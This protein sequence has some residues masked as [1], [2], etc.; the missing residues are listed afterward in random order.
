MQKGECEMAAVYH[1][2]SLVEYAHNE[3][4]S[5]IQHGVYM[6]GSKLSALEIAA[7]LGISRTPVVMAINQ[8]VSEGFA[9]RT[10]SRCT[11]VTQL[12]IPQVREI[13]QVR[14]MIELYTADLIVKNLPFQQAIFSQLEQTSQSM[15]E[16]DNHDYMRSCE[17]ETQFHTTFISLCSNSRI[18]KQ[19]ETNW[20]VG[21]VFLLFST[22]QMP[23]Y[24]MNESRIQHQE[25]LELAR[26]GNAAGIRSVAQ[27]HMKIVNDTLDW[28]IDN[29]G[30]SI[31][32][33]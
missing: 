24:R 14:E 23:L 12:R 16:M 17:L 2:D 26:K 6:P 13:L 8:L 9:E 7:A 31:F 27:K 4:Q 33:L 3:I 10:S 29:G 15:M 1:E 30:N 25:M 18:I 19:Y 32:K 28:L 11:V 22:S 20:G 5:R 21:I